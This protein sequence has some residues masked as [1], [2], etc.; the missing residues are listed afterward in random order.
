MKI[1]DLETHPYADA[2]SL[3]V[4]DRWDS[5]R[6]DIKRNGLQNTKLHRYGGKLL[7]GRNRLLV[8]LELV[9]TPEFVDHGSDEDPLAL[10]ISLNLHRRHDN[11]SQRAL[12]ALK[13]GTLK[14]GR[15][16]K[17][18]QSGGVSTAAA[19]AAL[20]VNEKTIELAKE[21]V[22]A[23]TPNVVAAVE[24]G[25]LTLAAAA[26]L[27]K[28]E[29]DAQDAALERTLQHDTKPARGAAARAERVAANDEQPDARAVVMQAIKRTL[30]ALGGTMRSLQDDGLEVAIH[31]KVLGIN[32][33]VRE[34][35]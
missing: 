34:A 6:D 31:G 11:P 8:C 23:T 24:R 29:R 9:I 13:L 21:V 17:H 7:D 22:K 2:F 30:R 4:G 16:K 26:A 27:G 15:P 12:S 5:F 1:G 35:A 28:L 20:G 14:P 3:L 32:I 19:A 33:T 10:V 18:A 25:D